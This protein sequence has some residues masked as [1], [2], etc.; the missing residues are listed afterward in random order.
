MS[1]PNFKLKH[2]EWWT[3][4]KKTLPLFSLIPTRKHDEEGGYLEAPGRTTSFF[5][6]MVISETQMQPIFPLLHYPNTL[7]VKPQSF[8][9][10]LCK[11]TF[12]LYK[13]FLSPLNPSQPPPSLQTRLTSPQ[14]PTPIG[15]HFFPTNVSRSSL[16]HTSPPHSFC[17]HPYTWA[18]PLPP[19][20][21]PQNF[22]ISHSLIQDP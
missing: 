2:G 5:S 22:T 9:L 7:L 13:Y 16:L 18:F 10:S 12:L 4:T 21:S 17:E 15:K 8:K 14:S 6:D 19:C 1:A 3:H 20:P 11:L